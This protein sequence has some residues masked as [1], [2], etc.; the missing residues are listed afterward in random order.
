MLRNH[1]PVTGLEAKFSLE[2]AVAS[3]LVA[4]SVGLAELTDTFVN[5]PAVQRLMGRVKIQA[6]DGERCPHE[7]VFALHDR[8]EIELT[9]GRVLPSGD[10]RFA[11]G[12]A[13]LPLKPADLR[14]KF[15]DCTRDAQDIDAEA[16]FDRLNRLHELPRVAQLF[17]G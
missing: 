15:L 4:R 16:L 13:M 10:L 14:A 6:V 17:R 3:S 5:Q 9:D 2:F 8:I 12:N 7:P 1:R 11:R